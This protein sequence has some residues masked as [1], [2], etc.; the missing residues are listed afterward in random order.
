MLG[1][2]IYLPNTATME[3]TFPYSGG[4]SYFPEVTITGGTFLDGVY[5]GWCVDT[6]H[7]IFQNTPYTVEVYSSYETIDGLVENP[8]NIDLVN[9]ILNQGYVG[10][11]VQDAFPETFC[12]G[13]I[14]YGDV[15]RAIWALIEDGQAT[16][17][18]GP[19]SQ[20]RVDEILAAA[21]AYG[22]GYEPGCGDIV[23]IIL[24]P[25]NGT[26]VIIA[27][28][29]IAELTILC[30]TVE[31]TAWGDG[32][33]FPGKNWAMYFPYRVQAPEPEPESVPEPIQE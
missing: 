29:V 6:D 8:E 31:E 19:W 21:Y 10:Q 22:E 11:N 13:T 2:E 24:A 12:T 5:S 9:W 28:V 30:E 27:Q 15:Q 32:E 16:S 1:L 7:N 20:C 25:V 26:Q 18:L 17:G 23:A 33:D 14:T 3:I 4:P